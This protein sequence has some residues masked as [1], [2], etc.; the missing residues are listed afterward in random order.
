MECGDKMKRLI[1]LVLALLVLSQAVYG[2]ELVWMNY[3]NPQEREVFEQLIEDFESS[4]PGV[5]IKFLSVEQNQYDA[6]INAAFS[7]N[8][9]PDVFYVGPEDVSFYVDK[10]R[11]LNLSGYVRNVKNVDFNDLYPNAVNKYRY[12]G[13]ALGTGDI[14]ALPKDL[15]PFALAYNKDMFKKYG[16]PIPSK[17]RPLT[18]EQFLEAC[19]MCTKDLNGDGQADTYGTALDRMFS[20]IQFIWG[21]GA[22]FL[23]ESKTKVTVTDPAFIKATQYWCDLISKNK[24]SPSIQEQNKKAPYFRWIDGELGFFPAAPWDLIAFSSLKFDYDL[25]PWPVADETCSTATWLGSIGYGVSSRT[26]HPEL[27]AEFAL[28]LSAY[29][30]TMKKMCDLDMQ[31]P[32]LMSLS[33]D[34]T[35]KTGKPDNREEYI[36]IISTT[37]RSWPEQYTYNNAWY[38]KFF[39]E[40]Q[41]VVDGKETAESYCYRIEPKMQRLLDRASKKQKA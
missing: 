17:S 9:A 34:Y 24:V 14:W 4:H 1:Y 2:Q 41:L 28:Y 23:D 32:T 12:D 7:S 10:H 22:D 5:T 6:K 39:S 27:A 21:S 40:F 26:K 25:I 15:G 8:N 33:N 35:R 18:F 16:I 37:G 36:N 11:L 19:K 3:A 20:F 13:I 38:L 30:S 31:V 29:K